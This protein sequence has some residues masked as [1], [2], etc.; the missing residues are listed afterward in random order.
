MGVGEAGEIVPAQRVEHDREGYY[1]FLKGLPPASQIAVESVGNWY[2]LI[3]ESD[4]NHYLKWDLTEAANVI[5]LRQHLMTGRHVVRL[6]RRIRQNKGHAKAIRA[7]RRHPAEAAYL[8][9]RSIFIH[10]RHNFCKSLACKLAFLF[11]HSQNS[12]PTHFPFLEQ[13]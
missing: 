1:S 2:P 5:V 8:T 13:H 6:Y 4:V 11:G 3:D 9:N 7:L 12:C 10:A